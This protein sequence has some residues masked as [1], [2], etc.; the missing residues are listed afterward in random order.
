[1]TLHNTLVREE[2]RW[3]LDTTQD[4]ANPEE[5]VVELSCGYFY[6]CL[7]TLLTIISHFKNSLRAS[8]PDLCRGNSLGTF[9]GKGARKAD[10]KNAAAKK[11]LAAINQIKALKG[12]KSCE[13][14]SATTG[15]LTDSK[16]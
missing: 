6:P 16:T 8:V 1:M 3:N 12:K 5:W 14:E 13:P 7:R 9:N 10:A 15:V 4:P 2:I 11:A